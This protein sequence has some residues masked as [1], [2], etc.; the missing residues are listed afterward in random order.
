[1][2][3]ESESPENSPIQHSTLNISRLL[4]DRSQPLPNPRRP[5]L[6]RLLRKPLRLVHLDQWR[7]L[8]CRGGMHASQLRK[9]LFHRHRGTDFDAEAGQV[10]GQEIEEGAAAAREIDDGNAGDDE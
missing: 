8:E 4:N 6:F 5:S 3:N 1:M 9:R 7:Q 10:D 2:L